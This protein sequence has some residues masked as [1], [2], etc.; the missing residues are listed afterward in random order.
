MEADV[1]KPLLALVRSDPFVHFVPITVVV[2]A[3][4]GLYVSSGT[5]T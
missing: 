4:I 1:S 5:V 3:V 2:E